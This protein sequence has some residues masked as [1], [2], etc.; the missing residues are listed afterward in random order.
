MIITIPLILINTNK[1]N[2]VV[3]NKYKKKTKTLETIYKGKKF[4]AY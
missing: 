1:Y 2:T 3:I 4:K